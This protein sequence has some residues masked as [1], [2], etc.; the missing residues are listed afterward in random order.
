MQLP[1]RTVR[2]R[3][4]GLALPLK[5]DM[6]RAASSSPPS[7]LSAPR[8][9]SHQRGRSLNNALDASHGRPAG[10]DVTRT[11]S[12]GG[13]S[14]FK[15]F[16]RK[17]KSNGS[18]RAQ[19]AKDAAASSSAVGLGAPAARPPSRARSHSRTASA[20]NILLRSFG[21]SAGAAVAAQVGATGAGAGGEGEN[22]L[23]WAQR[24]RSA[25]V[26]QL[27]AKELGRLRARLRNEAP[28]CVFPFIPARSLAYAHLM[29]AAGSTNSSRTEDTSECSSASKSCSKWSGGACQVFLPPLM[30]G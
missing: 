22:A 15:S 27:D 9:P 23:H 16:L 10:P 13:G 25:C 26:A 8:R 24:L 18:L 29:S 28:G 20:T 2:T 30:Q 19:N 14:G 12:S 4:L 6:L 7:S 5:E 21:K 3:M 1:D 17:T 11:K